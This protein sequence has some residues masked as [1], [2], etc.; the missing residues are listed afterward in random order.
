[1]RSLVKII[2]VSLYEKKNCRSSLQSLIYSQITNRYKCS[3]A[4]NM[5]GSSLSSDAVK[6]CSAWDPDPPKILANDRVTFFNLNDIITW[7]PS[8][9]WMLSDSVTH[10]REAVFWGKGPWSLG[11]EGWPSQCFF[12]LFFFITNTHFGQKCDEESVGQAGGQTGGQTLHHA[13]LWYMFSSYKLPK[14]VT[15]TM[16]QLFGHVTLLCGTFLFI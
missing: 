3:L 5:D 13:Q 7:S 4:S 10:G 15:V 1:M 2:L 16:V 6:M 11:L 14:T 12:F 9:N 8:V